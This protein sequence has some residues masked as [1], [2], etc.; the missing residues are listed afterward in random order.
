MN[1]ELYTSKTYI[2]WIR[3]YDN[4]SFNIFI[5]KDYLL[6]LMYHKEAVDN[7]SLKRGPGAVL[8]YNSTKDGVDTADEMLRDYLSKSKLQSLALAVFFKYI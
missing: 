2:L 6:P 7:D 3:E 1:Y 8:F 5:K 4:I